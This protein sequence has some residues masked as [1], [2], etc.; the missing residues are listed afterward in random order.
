MNFTEIKEI[1][2]RI[3]RGY[4][5]TRAEALELSQSG[6]IEA[7]Y[8]SAN[9]L[10]AKFCG[11]KFEMCSMFDVS[12]A[13]IIH[14]DL[15]SAVSEAFNNSRHHLFI[16]RDHTFCYLYVKKISWNVVFSDRF[17]HQ[18]QHV[19]FNEIK[20]GE[21]NRNRK[22]RSATFHVEVNITAD[23]FYH[24]TIQFMDHFIFL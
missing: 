9:Q 13:K 22:N 15:V 18:L 16:L 17:L 2:D 19:T 24:E 11:F 5:I 3:M 21:V 10:R 20:S 6:H 8:Y 12:R 1:K 23:F 4:E 14:P 7:L